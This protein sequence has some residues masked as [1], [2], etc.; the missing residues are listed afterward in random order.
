[1]LP[2]RDEAEALTE[3]GELGFSLHAAARNGDCWPVSVLASA[4]KITTEEAAAPTPLTDGKVLATRKQGIDLVTAAR[5]GGVD[6]N[7]VR[8]QEL[9]LK[10]TPAASAKQLAPWKA[11]RKWR[12]APGDETLAS[13]FQFGVAACVRPTAV[14]ERG[15]TPG[16]LLDPVKVYA[17]TEGG[18]LR[19]TAA[20]TAA[21]HRWRFTR[22]PA[23]ASTR[24]VY[25]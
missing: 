1:M 15:T 5:I 23:S 19:R 14:L 6:G 16:T 24:C 13:A 21:S 10:V 8:R 20:S 7:E 11:L 22:C 25:L 17:L 12:T 4:N 3:L 2:P 18:S 9:G